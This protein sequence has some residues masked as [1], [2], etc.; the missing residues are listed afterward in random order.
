MK[1]I[2]ILFLIIT[3]LLAL[4]QKNIKHQNLIWYGYFQ[5][6]EMSKNW[7][8]ESE[9]QERHFIDPLV[10]HQLLIRTHLHRKLGNGWEASAGGCAFF[11]NSNDPGAVINLTVPELRPHVE[12]AYK[13]ELK[14]SSIEYRYRTEFRFYH[15]T[16]QDRTALE[17][18]YTFSNIR[19][20]YRVQAVM[21]VYNK[22]KIKASNELH[23][24]AGNK[25]VKNVFD[26][27]RLYAGLSY[28][29]TPNL[30]IDMGYMNWFQQKS[31]GSFFSRD[32][33]RFTIYQNINKHKHGK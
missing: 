17:Q 6:I 10:Q 26:Q 18:G 22:L 8:L 29:S 11:Q 9:I 13:Q 4:S 14:K 5:K 12:F 7:Y 2:I 28:A 31:D 1:R 33:L 3:P 27:N 15:N 16:N 19:F 20:R 21:P 25:I 30:S 23:I 24:N 32:I